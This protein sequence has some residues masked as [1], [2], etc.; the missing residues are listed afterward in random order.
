MA[1]GEFISPSTVIEGLSAIEM[2]G[3]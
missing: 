2:G 1:Y 3:K